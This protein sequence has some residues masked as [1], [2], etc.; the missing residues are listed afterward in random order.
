MLDDD[1]DADADEA[2]AAGH[3]ARTVVRWPST[4]YL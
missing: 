4:A 2:H 3:F 1:A